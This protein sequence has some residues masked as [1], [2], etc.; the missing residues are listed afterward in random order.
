MDRS[1]AAAILS[2]YTQIVKAGTFISHTHCCLYLGSSH[3][4]GTVARPAA[5]SSFP[6]SSFNSLILGLS[7]CL[8]P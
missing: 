3:W 8:G 4:G 6:E 2:F 7:V 5:V 1:E